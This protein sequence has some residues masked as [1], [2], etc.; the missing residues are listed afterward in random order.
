MQLSKL[1]PWQFPAHILGFQ[2]NSPETD[3]L[4][5]PV[6]SERHPYFLINFRFDKTTEA[7]V[8]Y[9]GFDNL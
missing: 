1:T 6:S 5:D 2:Y 3:L 8:D 7:I 9:S 4:N